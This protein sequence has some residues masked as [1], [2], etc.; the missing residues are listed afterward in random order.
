[1]RRCGRAAIG[2]TVSGRGFGSRFRGAAFAKG[3]FARMTGAGMI[4]LPLAMMSVSSFSVAFLKRFHQD[5]GVEQLDG[6]S[7]VLPRFCPANHRDFCMALMSSPNTFEL[8]HATLLSHPHMRSAL[9]FSLYAPFFK[10]ANKVCVAVHFVDIGEQSLQ[11][12][13][14]RPEAASACLQYVHPSC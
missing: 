1:M 10:V 14:F 12:A 6:F 3:T 5:I 9:P 8:S 7:R 13:K 2:F 11:G 4:T